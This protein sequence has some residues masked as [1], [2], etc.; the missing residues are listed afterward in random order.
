M[1]INVF[2]YSMI[3]GISTII[4]TL[5]IFYKYE[6]ARRNSIHLMSFAAGIMLA[7]AF[8]HLIPEAIEMGVNLPE[9]HSSEAEANAH[10]ANIVIFLVLLLGFTVFYAIE[11]IMMIHPRH[12]VN[13]NDK[14]KHGRLSVL[15]VTGLTFHSLIDGIIIAVGFKADY[16]I[17]LMTTIAVILHEMPEGIITTSI[18]LHDNMKRKLVFWF[19]I[20][21][22]LATPFG[23]IFSYALLGNISRIYLSYLLSIAAGSL[24]YISASDLIPETIKGEKRLNTVF[25]IIGMASLYIIGRIIGH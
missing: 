24:I 13:A 1:F 10:N 7:L 16:K 11:N 20:L 14:N 18:L 21:V 3:A 23:A 19:S 4:G 12:D 22:A 8:I 17:G 6:W 25:L 9:G 5:L 15:S 2:V